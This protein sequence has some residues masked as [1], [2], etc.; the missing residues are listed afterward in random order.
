MEESDEHK[1]VFEH[2]YGCL[3]VLDDKSSALL[4]FNS[5]IMAVFALFITGEKDGNLVALIPFFGI[6]SV[7]LSSLFLL[8]VV[9]IHW[10]STKDFQ[11]LDIHRL[12]LLDI[13]RDRTA[14]YWKAWWLSFTSIVL[15]F[16]YLLIQLFIPLVIIA[17]GN[18]FP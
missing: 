15:L 14:K 4:G 6:F 16:F 18:V 11:D 8:F 2:L 12:R 1:K 5:I 13:R 3:T 9:L 17:W 7:M 10:S